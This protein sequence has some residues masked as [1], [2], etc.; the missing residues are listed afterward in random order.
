MEYVYDF[1]MNVIEFYQ[2]PTLLVLLVIALFL[3]T[4]IVCV[5]A[6]VCVS[7]D[8]AIILVDLEVINEWKI[9]DCL[10]RQNLH[11]LGMRICDRCKVDR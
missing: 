7:V 5:C 11:I 10:S 9:E 6:C 4:L 8:I 2:I 3:C 1:L